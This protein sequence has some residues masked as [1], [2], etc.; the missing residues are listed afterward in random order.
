MGNLCYI[1]NHTKKIRIGS[2]KF[3]ELMF[4]NYGD[5]LMHLLHNPYP[6]ENRFDINWYGDNIE[7]ICDS[8][9]EHW[10]EFMVYED[11]TEYYYD[12]FKDSI[13]DNI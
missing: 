10:E 11:K 8:S 7:I 13:G 3:R 5:I 4:A 2:A 6:W 9:M 12:M 1:A